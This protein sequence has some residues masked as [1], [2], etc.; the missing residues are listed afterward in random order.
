[1]HVAERLQ[2]NLTPEE[3]KPFKG[4][5]RGEALDMA[6]EL[7]AWASICMN[8]AADSTKSLLAEELDTV[9]QDLDAVE[10]KNTELSCCPEEAW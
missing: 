8:Y 7:N 9:R 1:M 5:S 2:F 6:Y 3:N 10:K 4:M